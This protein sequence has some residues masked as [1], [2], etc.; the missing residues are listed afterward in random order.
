MRL[1]IDFY[2]SQFYPR[3]NFGEHRLSLE[4]S[5]LSSWVYKLQSGVGH[6]DAHGYQAIKS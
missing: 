5:Y 3:R 4:E 2:D 6:S 1:F